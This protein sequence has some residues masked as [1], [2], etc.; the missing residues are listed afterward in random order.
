MFLN[1]VNALIQSKRTITTSTQQN[2]LPLSNVYSQ[3]LNWIISCPIYETITESWW[4]SCSFNAAGVT[5]GFGKYL[6][7]TLEYLILYF[8][9]HPWAAGRDL[10]RWFMLHNA[11]LSLAGQAQSCGSV[12]TRAGA[13]KCWIDGREKERGLT[14][15]THTQ[16]S[17]EP[18]FILT[19]LITC[20]LVNQMVVI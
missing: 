16:P 17:W 5:E 11:W 12:R 13:F 8:S 2:V 14:D 20:W 19:K 18:V 4:S 6:T 3:Y 1:M 9:Q 7:S 15:W 10:I